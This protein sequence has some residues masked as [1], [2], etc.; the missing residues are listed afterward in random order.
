MDHHKFNAMKE[1]TS[2]FAAWKAVNDKVKALQQTLQLNDGVR[3]APLGD[4][5]LELQALQ[6]ESERLL[7]IASHALLKVKTPRSSN[8]DSTWG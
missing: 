7:L 5:E 2:T 4:L 3:Q 1:V 8:G 6:L